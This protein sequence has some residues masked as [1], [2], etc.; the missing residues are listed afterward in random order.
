MDRENSRRQFLRQLGALLLTAGAGSLLSEARSAPGKAASRRSAPT[1]RA[2]GG[3]GKLSYKVAQWTGD[4]FK[5][6]H[7]LRLKELPT[8]PIDADNNYDFIIVGGGVAGL[9]AAYYLK[10]H[11]VLL[12]EQ[13]DELGGQS[14]GGSYRGI[15]YSYGAAYVGTV[16]G[17]YGDLFAE[18][19][20]KAATLPP[21]RNAWYW[22]K[23]WYQDISGKDKCTLYKEFAQLV[24]QSKPIWRGMPEDPT[25][26]NV[27]NA[28]MIKLD[29]IRFIDVLKGYSPEFLALLDSFVRSSCCGGLDQVSALSGYFLMADLTT[30]S[31]VFEGGNS[32]IPRALVAKIEGAGKERL[33]RGAFVWDVAVDDDQASVIYSTKNGS[34]HRAKCRHVIITAPPLVAGRV[35]SGVDDKLKA[36]LLQM[37]FGSYLVANCL[38]NKQL[39][40]GTYDNWVSKPFT[41]ADITVAETPYMI[42]KSYKAQMGSVL[43]IYQ[44]YAPGSAGRSLLLVGNR[45]EFVSSIVGQ[46][47]MLVEHLSANLDEVV[48][49]RWGHAVAVPGPGYFARLRKIHAAVG[50]GVFSLANNSMQGFPS[51]ESAITAARIAADRALS[52]PAKVSTLFSR[53]R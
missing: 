38:L 31:Y 35:L 8:A 21:R 34:M 37:R 48:L 15:D 13:Y 11:N 3:A 42:N 19:G 51:A 12:L 29:N 24:Q 17:I 1:T 30:N 53:L 23:K 39:F 41:F 9:A 52:K 25:P 26:D 28:A 45:Q 5:L 44:P 40:S 22:Q 2:A 27:D 49:T 20:L 18:I 32:A 7:Q 10:D 46:L 33:V 14:R 50:H 6:G 47:S 4:D 43:T 36:Y 16:D